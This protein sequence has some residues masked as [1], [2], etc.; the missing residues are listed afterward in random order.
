MTL[1]GK[2]HLYPYRGHLYT[3]NT[4]PS[5][6]APLIW[7]EQ[8]GFGTTVTDRDALGHLLREWYTHRAHETIPGR[9]DHFASLMGLFPQKIRISDARSRWGSCSGKDTLSFSWRTVTLPAALMDYVV[10]HELA[11]LK[12]RNHGPAFWRLVAAFMPDHKTHRTWLRQNTR[13]FLRF[14]P[15]DERR[16]CCSTSTKIRRSRLRGTDPAL[17]LGGPR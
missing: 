15:P 13:S 14:M 10:V 8:N 5:Q 6:S 9:V 4:C 7:S 11:H 3:L 16:L 17:A 12:E 1:S 2:R